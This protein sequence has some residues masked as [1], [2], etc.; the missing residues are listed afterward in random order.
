MSDI[1][2]YAVVSREYIGLQSGQCLILAVTGGASVHEVE[3][4]KPRK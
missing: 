4:S 1:G 3:A 2:M